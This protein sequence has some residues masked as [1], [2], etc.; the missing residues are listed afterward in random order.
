MLIEIGDDIIEEATNKND[1]ALNVL[2]QLSNAYRFGKHLVFITYNQAAKIKSI[3]YLSRNSKSV[4]QYLSSKLSEMFVFRDRIEYRAYVSF[5]NPEK[6]HVLWINPTV[7]KS[8]ELYEETHLLAENLLDIDFYGYVATYYKVKHNLRKCSIC[9][10]PLQGGG[11]TTKDVYLKEIKLK[12]H[13]CLAIMD[14]DKKYPDGPFGKTSE[15]L[16]IIHNKEEPFNCMF[17][18]MEKL[19]E[20]ENMIPINII[21]SYARYIHNNLLQQ[22]IDLSFI[23][24]KKGL[25]CC[26][27]KERDI[28]NY[29]SNLISGESKRKMELC[30]KC[31]RKHNFNVTKEKKSKCG[32][33]QNILDGLGADLM[34]NLLS[35]GK[36]KG[37]L[38]NVQIGLLTKNQHE[39]WENIGKLICEWCCS[40]KP[41]RV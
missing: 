29:Y 40:G 30:N 12:Q 20:I 19:S 28:Y 27:I 35:D 14:G 38:K 22:E 26:C 5:N 31:L 17:Y 24:M 32:K 15:E 7:H 10:F 3:Q 41:I 25:S 36:I 39:E 37:L 13:F 21:K 2:E 9:Y 1:V 34:K 8:F 6:G 4:Y 33:R 18:R 16:C 11:S 23:D